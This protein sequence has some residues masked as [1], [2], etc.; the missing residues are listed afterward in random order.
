MQSHE[1]LREVFKVTS[2]KQIAADLNLSLSMIYKWAEPTEKV[3]GSGL[4]NPLDRIDQL[5]KSTHDPRLPQWICERAGGFFIH[6]PKAHWPHPYQ[7]IPATNQIVQEFADM[8]GVIATA[9]GDNQV[10]KTE[11]K[12]IRRRWEDLKRVTEGFVRGC[13]EGNF[14]NSKPSGLPA[15]PP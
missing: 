5:I 14:A 9:A 13:E 1:L 10:T 3:E 12:D 2:A 7:V 8:L 6:N 11:A 15:P 4:A